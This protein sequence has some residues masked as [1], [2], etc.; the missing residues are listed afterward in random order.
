MRPRHLALLALAALALW[1]LL[2]FDGRLHWDE[3]QYLY[4]GAYS[5]VEQIVSGAFQPNGIAGFNVSRIVH[6]LQIKGIAALFGVG[7]QL[8]VVVM[9]LHLAALL[10]FL[11][12]LWAILRE[13][14]VP[15]GQAAVGTLIVMVSPIVLYLAF[16]TLPDTPALMT[17]TLAVL[18]LLRL[19]RGGKAWLWLAIGALALALTALTKHVLVW[20]VV[21]FAVAALIAVP[22]D[23]P[24]TRLL[25]AVCALSLASIALFAVAIT[26][27]GLDLA[28][29]L[30]FIRAASQATEPFAARGLHLLITLGV[31]WVLVAIAALPP[32]GRLTRFFWLWFAVAVLP[33]LLLVPRLEIR[34]LAPAL[35]P[36]AG[37]VIAALDWLQRG[38]HG[39]GSKPRAQLAALLALIAAIG[40]SSRALQGITAHEVEIGSLHTLLGRLD[41][42]FGPAG[43]AIVT[44]WEY[45]TFLYLRVAYP[46]HH[47]Y[48]AYDPTS[49]GPPDG[50][51]DRQRHFAGHLL[52][53]LDQLR[54]IDTPL[55]YVGFAEAMPIANLRRL[56]GWLPRTIGETLLRQLD[57]LDTLEHLTLSWMWDAPELSF[58][59]LDQ[60]GNYLA[61]RVTLGEM[62][63]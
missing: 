63:R 53:D 4:A 30:N 5:P 48:D 36:L 10:A 43:Y 3:P 32:H 26:L 61:Y 18:A 38:V 49:A 46:E 14:T 34:Y 8:I 15:A 1:L 56:A 19:V 42:T 40:L 33:Y 13:L 39:L 9:A 60:E 16:K 25:R 2:G 54:A 59:P 24:R 51:L 47:V 17:S 11:V 23:L 52:R 7:G 20:T 31:L 29:F 41:A 45:S 22:G 35:L 57:A 12:I 44:P 28:H 21:A 37:L 27:P 50:F 55:V 6:V 62:F 58:A